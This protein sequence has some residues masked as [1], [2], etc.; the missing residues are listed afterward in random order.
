MSDID[1]LTTRTKQWNDNSSPTPPKWTTQDDNFDLEFGEADGAVPL[2][3]QDQL[4]DSVNKMR[5]KETEEI[6]AVKLL[7]TFNN[8]KTEGE[9]KN[10]VNILRALNHYHCIRVL[11]SYRYRDWFGIVT[12]PVAQCDLKQYLSEDYGWGVKCVESACGPRAS[13]LPRIMGCLAYTLH[14]IHDDPQVRHRDIKPENIL[15]DGKRVL[16]AD[17]GLSKLYTETQSGSSGTSR[18][19]PMVEYL[20]SFGAEYA[21]QI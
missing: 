9:L 3:Y 10:E 18:K 8:L 4:G 11:G 13:F 2:E 17:F 16:F 12:Q 1:F 5:C 7:Q 20:L 6:V 19:T 14:Y 21:N 15:L